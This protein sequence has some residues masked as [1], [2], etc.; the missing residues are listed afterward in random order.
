MKNNLTF[1]GEMVVVLVGILEMPSMWENY[2]S[3]MEKC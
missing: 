3:Y 2:L 1:M